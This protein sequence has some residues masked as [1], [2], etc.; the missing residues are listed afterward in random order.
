MFSCLYEELAGYVT[1]E[2]RKTGRKETWEEAEEE[3]FEEN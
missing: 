2:K 3:L 1:N